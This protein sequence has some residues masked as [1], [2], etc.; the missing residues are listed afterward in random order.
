[1][2]LSVAGKIEHRSPA[3]VLVVPFWKGKK[4]PELAVEELGSIKKE[5]TAPLA[6]HDFKGKEEEVSLIYAHGQ[7]EKRILLLGLGEQ[8]K[9]TVERLRRAYAAVTKFSLKKKLSDINVILPKIET[10]PQ[11][12]MV[13]GVVEGLLLP[14]Y[15]FTT[16]KSDS[17]K[18]EKPQYLEKICLVGGSKKDLENAETILEI[19]KGV[20]FTR[21]LVNGNADDVTPQHLA[22]VAMDLAKK[23]KHLKT[24][25]FD[26]K[27][28]EREKMGLLLAVNRGSHMDPVFMTIEYKGNPKSS[29]HTVLVG[30]GIT[31][32]TGGL[33]LKP[34][35]SMETMRT[36]MSGA[37][38]VLGVMKVISK[39]KLKVN[40][41]GVIASTE[42]AID[43][44][45]YKP[46]DVYKSRAGK[47][48]ENG[49]TD[50]E[51]RLV[52][53]D[54]LSY[55]VDHLKP[56]R[57]IDF[58]T[59]TGAID[60]ALGNEAAGLFTNNDVLAD[61]LIRAGSETGERLWRLP[62]YEEYRDQL[63]SDVADIKSTGGR[64]AGSITAAM[65]LQEFIGK[66]PWAHLDIA[67]IS[68]STEAR[69]YHPKLGTGMGVR[70]AV[71]LLQN[72]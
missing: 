24:T 47:T 42:N 29:D 1:M 45:S 22:H 19:C 66:V 37:A 41:T 9:V 10:I 67:S 5:M 7:P 39:L 44:K 56:T 6:T 69:R 18:D 16:L 57:I 23:D 58:A 27:R 59:L 30:K 12:D 32:D 15:G 43:S 20:Y 55:A 60:V 8:E 2:H 26:K 3:D 61:F 4:A 21:D 25:V 49:N 68:F 35:G 14:N 28:I 17:I 51:G 54:A 70:L 62:L 33:N 36:D 50:A 52:L 48:V 46:G 13:R 65:F 31:F 63:K 64:S 38:I 53:A 72:L 34:T 71:S 11:E 40:V